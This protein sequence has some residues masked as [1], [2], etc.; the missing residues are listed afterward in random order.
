MKIPTT[1]T[2]AQEPANPP[3]VAPRR[4]AEASQAEDYETLRGM[5]FADDDNSFAT[6]LA[7]VNERPQDQERGNQNFSGQD[8]QQNN[9]QS[10]SALAGKSKERDEDDKADKASRLA[11]QNNPLREASHERETTPPPV[12]AILHISDLERIVAI[13]RVTN[14]PN[15]QEVLLQL[16]NSIF[17]GLRVKISIG[18][19]GRIT[20]EFLAGQESIRAQLEARSAQLADVLRNRGIKLAEVKTTL[21]SAFSGSNDQQRDERGKEDVPIVSTVVTDKMEL[22]I[23]QPRQSDL[24]ESSDNT[25][26]A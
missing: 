15:G 18:Q 6:V 5:S 10:Q 19:S 7:R 3:R 11:Q 22:T 16:P 9:D 24:A 4:F 13:C 23:D 12:R 17:A 21:D 8:S 1:P 14:I 20:T 2:P 26:L 25:Y